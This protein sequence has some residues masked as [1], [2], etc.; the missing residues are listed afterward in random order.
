MGKTSYPVLI[1]SDILEI[2]QSSVESVLKAAPGASRLFLDRATACVGCGFARF[3]TLKE[4]IDRYDLDE[5][6]FLLPLMEMLA[7]KQ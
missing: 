5:N 6:L 1:M 7:Q 3:C 2:Y 4:V